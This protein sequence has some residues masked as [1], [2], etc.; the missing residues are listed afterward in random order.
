LSINAFA[1]RLKA[2]CKQNRDYEDSNKTRTAAINSSVTAS[3]I[4]FNAEALTEV[5]LLV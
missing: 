4:T 2:E 1:Q 5:K 3:R